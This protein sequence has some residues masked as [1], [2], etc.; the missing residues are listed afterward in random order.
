MSNSD[1]VR[2]S[3]DGDYFHYLW[4]A[5]RCLAL[6]SPTSDL[7]AVSIEGASTSEAQTGTATPVGEEIIDVAEYYGQQDLK[8]AR[9]VCYYQLKHSTQNPTDDWTA[10]GLQKTLKGFAGRYL[11]L[12]DKFGS[13]CCGKKLKFF[14]VSNRPV[15]RHILET[16][17][18]AASGAKSRHPK[19][20]T[21]IEE[22]TGLTGDELSCFCKLLHLEGNHD[23]Y[24]DQRNT[25]AQDV[26]EYLPDSDVDAPVQLTELVHRKALSE[27]STNPTIT[28]IDVLRALKTDEGRLFPAPCLIARIPALVQ[29]DQEELLTAEIVKAEFTPILIH[30]DGG[31]G[32]SV[33]STKI[34]RNLPEGS[35]CI[36]YD[37]FGNGQYRSASAYRHRHEDALV[38][39]ANEMASLGLCHPLIRTPNAD[40]TRYLRAFKHRIKQAITSIRAKTPTALLC[41]IVDAAD[42]AQIAAEEIGES[43]SFVRDLIRESL[44]TGVRLVATCRTHRRDLLDPPSNTLHL[45]LSSFSRSETASL[46]RQKFPDATEADV[47][48]FH[49][50]SSQNP[51][52][53]ATALATSSPLQEMLRALGPNPSTADDSISRLLDSAISKLRDD[54]GAAEGAKIELI[55]AGLAT[56]RP[57]IPISVLAELSG[58]EES[59]VRSFANDLGR[60][61][62]IGTGTIQFFD[63]PAETW[64][65]QR[66]KPSTARLSEFVALLRPLASRN[67]YVAATLP[68]LMLE[69]G[70]FSELVELALT[71]DALPLGS[72]LEK[73]EVE[74]QR[75]QFALKASLRVNCY[76]EAAKLSLKAGC[77]TAGEGRQ[78]TL[79]QENS[80]LAAIFFDTGL[81]QEIVARRAFRSTWMGA[82]HA[83][84]AGL[85]SGHQDLRADARSRLRMAHE[86]LSNFSSRRRHHESREQLQ[87]ADIAELA[88]AHLN[89]YGSENATKFLFGLSPKVF[90]FRVMRLLAGRLLDHERYAELD[91]LAVAAGNRLSLVLAIT[92]ELRRIHRVPPAAVITRALRLI[93]HTKVRLNVGH[94]Y[95]HELNLLGAITCLVEAGCQ[96]KA[97]PHDQLASVLKRYL[98]E[99]PPRGLASPYN[100]NRFVYMRAYSL[101]AGLI[102]SRLSLVDVAHPELQTALKKTN[103]VDASNDTR[104]FKEQIGAVL[105]WHQLWVDIFL[106]KIRQPD[107]AAAVSE[108]HKA[109]SN[110][111]KYSY[112]N[113]RHTEN[114]I[115]VLW[116]DALVMAGVTQSE[117]LGDFDAW[118]KSLDSPLFTPTLTKMAWVTARYAPL[119]TRSFTYARQSFD[120]TFSERED[121]S[122]KV[123]SFVD[124]TRA[125]LATS[126]AE[127][128][129]YFNQAIEVASHTGDENLD[130]WFSIL[131]LADHAA[132][133]NAPASEVAYQLSRCAELTYEHVVRDK[134]FDWEATVHAIAGLCPS[135]CITILSRWRDRGFGR[136]ERLFPEA[137]DSLVERGFL[138]PVVPLALTAF[139]YEWDS[140]RYLEVAL[141]KMTSLSQKK[142]AANYVYRYMR[143]EEHTASTW[144]N[145]KAAAEQHDIM[146]E[147]IDHVISACELRKQRQS[148]EELLSRRSSSTADWNALFHGIDLSNP[149]LLS[150]VYAKVCELPSLYS[151]G[152]FFHEA[153]QRVQI[154]SEAAFIRALPAVPKFNR[155]VMRD[156]F[157]RLPDAW[158]SRLSVQA[159]LRDMIRAICRRDCLEISRHRHFVM[160]PF[161]KAS[162]L[163]NFSHKEISQEIL[164]AIAE[165]SEPLEC[166]RLFSLCGLLVLQLDSEQSLDVLNY[167]L[168]LFEPFLDENDGDGPWCEELVPPETVAESVAGYVW[169]ALADPS[170]SL[171]WQA[172]HVVRGLTLL[173]C[174]DV[175]S[176]LLAI[177]ES[178]KSGPFADRTLHFYELHAVQWLLIALARSATE[179]PNAVQPHVAYLLQIF[180]AN[181]PHLLIDV[182]AARALLTLFDATVFSPTDPLL[183]ALRS[184]SKF[185]KLSQE[186]LAALGRTNA[187]L[188]QSQKSG[189]PTFCFE[190]GVTRYWFS[191]L[192]GFFGMK[193]NEVVWLAQSVV[194]DW[195]LQKL[196]TWK[197]DQRAVRSLY[198]EN[199]TYQ[200]SGDYPKTDSLRFYISYQ[201]MMTVAGS[202]FATVA[203]NEVSEEAEEE[204]F[205]WMQRHGLTRMDGS[206]LADRRDPRPIECPDWPD[207]RN[208]DEWRWSPQPMDFDRYLGR[209]SSRL[210]LWGSWSACTGRRQEIVGISSALVSRERSNALLRAL[211]TANNADDYRIPDAEDELQID[212]G[213]Y[214]L[215]GWILE[216]H[217]DSGLD[218]LDPWAGDIRYPP[219]R[220]SETIARILP[221]ESDGE[222]RSWKLSGTKD[223]VILCEIWG[224]SMPSDDDEGVQAGRRLTVSLGYLLELLK[225]L[226]HDLVVKVQVKRSI[227]RGNEENEIGYIWPYTRVYIIKPDGHI[228]TL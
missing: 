110:A 87:D 3:R 10:S 16:I 45:E 174:G 142:T 187:D 208:L 223:E 195:G 102:G 212:H 228:G 188:Q 44:G 39:I 109:S 183:N 165:R 24:W 30:A 40:V 120:L 128:R 126:H 190:D 157:E 160:F 175:L 118:V 159:A 129:E 1:L 216:R 181:R 9:S 17:A 71:S 13:D 204:L 6:L 199:E 4:A 98:P 69:A 84:E 72:L 28:K 106:G 67:S 91:D 113:R 20:L 203:R 151:A 38:Q 191:D 23:G 139:R 152:N 206:W 178:R 184:V 211:Q 90:Q 179:S 52:V 55:C 74:L 70:Q 123:T 94:E 132:N 101:M 43:R 56:L 62:M 77:E 105:P 197:N 169:A 121:A 76:V 103:S 220:P 147:E 8:L 36:L 117:D 33:F 58:V 49:R 60:P 209:T 79:I 162:E 92:T 196:D 86:W 222:E 12:C 81:I 42:N 148:E 108:A 68:Q 104:E 124:L 201:S 96:S 200:S 213:A 32:K 27:S 88:M 221:I 107:T 66:F 5:R 57:L 170:A 130:R 133:S 48:E 192:G 150:V 78:Q 95:D 29:R 18:D 125:L 164:N 82:H 41:I 166:G 217:P 193:S 25:L 54:N 198:P 2:F 143:L 135:S 163:S 202:L 155:F 15:S 119:K 219:I 97:L 145:L 186:G 173:G 136:E 73:K 214:Q 112:R 65:R 111:A 140:P 176:K 207:T 127:S 225:L 172:S 11:D 154:G 89:I 22:H 210:H 137:V 100:R 161:D 35:V 131:D 141:S 85:L 156:F 138:D 47:N 34:G 99:Q 189:K 146:L 185:Q 194:E 46:L 115:A 182:L 116:L 37:C 83:Y 215:K 122:S 218:S 171:R 50:L 19:E 93:R 180:R 53:Q 114:E 75:L 226:N 26:S 80:D 59:A 224:Q 227:L 63:E 177:A 64:F 51:R 158:K 168:K 31:V 14:F 7:V 167:G 205:Y 149:S 144:K 21:K 153:F 61:L 134:H